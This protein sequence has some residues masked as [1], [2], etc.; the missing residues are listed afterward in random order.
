MKTAWRALAVLSITGFS[1]MVIA[2]PVTVIENPVPAGDYAGLAGQLTAAV[3]MVGF[4]FFSVRWYLTL[5]GRTHKVRS[6][7]W[8]AIL[9]WY[10]LLG[11]VMGLYI[12]VMA[13]V[14]NG[15]S[16]RRGEAVAVICGVFGFCCGIWKERLR[17]AEKTVQASA[18]SAV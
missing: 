9:F 16:A 4:L 17:A 2:T 5:S 18:A 11:I 8:A 3:L 12:I 1:L 15:F 14:E 10:S 13:L 7:A 6:Q